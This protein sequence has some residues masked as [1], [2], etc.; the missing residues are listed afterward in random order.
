MQGLLDQ[1]AEGVAAPLT[2][3]PPWGVNPLTWL[4]M[5]SLLMALALMFPAILSA[6]ARGLR[7]LQRHLALAAR[8]GH[9]TPSAQA[10]DAKLNAPDGSKQ[11]REDPRGNYFTV[12]DSR[13]PL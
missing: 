13:D 7:S 11:A 1:T 5:T 12:W 9:T 4:V 3:V 2:F 10:G 8:S 6:L